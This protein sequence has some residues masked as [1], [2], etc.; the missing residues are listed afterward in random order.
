MN[1]TY[2]KGF[3]LMPYRV[4]PKTRERKKT[5]ISALPLANAF[6][7]NGSREAG[8]RTLKD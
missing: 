4:S 1:E 5:E 7:K 8:A 6:V 3:T 2:E